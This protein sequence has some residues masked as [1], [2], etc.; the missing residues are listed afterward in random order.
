[1]KWA[2]LC[3]AIVGTAGVG[4]GLSPSSARAQGFPPQLHRNPALDAALS[5]RGLNLEYRWVVAGRP[6]AG[7]TPFRDPRS[8]APLAL[9]DTVVF[10]LTGAASVLVSHSPLGSSVALRLNDPGAR[11]LLRTTTEHQGEEIAVLIN[12]RLVT[13][14]LVSGPLTG[15]LPVAGDL[16]AEQANVLAERLKAAIGE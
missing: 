8:G 5:V 16:P 15:M 6:P 11:R 9:A 13:I 7:E 1:V 4:V 14:A 12:R 2:P 3:V 10:D